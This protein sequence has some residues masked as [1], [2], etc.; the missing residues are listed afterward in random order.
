MKKKSIKNIP[1]G[2]YCY[3]RLGGIKKSKKLITKNNPEGIYWP[4]KLCPYFTH[5]FNHDSGQVDAF[6]EYLKEFDFPLLDDQCKICNI[7][8]DDE[9]E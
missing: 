1:E 7:N 5:R 4:T 8:W 2:L 6:C 9:N 3:I